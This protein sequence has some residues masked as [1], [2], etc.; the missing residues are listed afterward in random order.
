MTAQEKIHVPEARV[1]GPDAGRAIP[2]PLHPI[3]QLV[4]GSDMPANVS[5]FDMTLAPRTPGAPPHVHTHE[6]EVYYVLEGALTFLL[7]TEVVTA[8]AG[9]TVILPRGHLHA[10][11]NEGDAPCRALTFVSQDT[12]F[13]H[14]FDDVA[15]RIAQAGEVPPERIPEIVGQAAAEIGVMIDMSALPA[16]GRPFFGMA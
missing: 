15:T 16:R 1:V 5:L 11:W 3:S 7:G 9:S 14:F 8:G 10:T 6:D 12:R 4:A 2:F 13:E